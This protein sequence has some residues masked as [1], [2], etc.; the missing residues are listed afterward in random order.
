MTQLKLRSGC[1][2][3]QDGLE[4]WYEDGKLH[5]IDGPAI[6]EPN[7]VRRWYQN[8]MLHRI[9][10]PA[11]E[12][13]SA[14]KGW[15]FEGQRHRIDGPAVEWELSREWYLH[16]E[17][18]EIIPQDVLINYM[19]ANNLEVIHLLVDNDPLVRKSVDK[20]NWVGLK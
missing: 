19:K 6:I 10:G 11:I 13:S 16:G 18:L 15:F 8:G 14:M 12:Y 3:Y 4:E 20:Y 2:K 7:G 5:R 9:G 17:R 1:T